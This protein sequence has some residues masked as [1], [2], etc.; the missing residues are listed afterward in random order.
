MKVF[1]F[2]AFDGVPW[3]GEVSMRYAALTEE[4]IRN[5]HEVIYITSSFSHIRK[6]FRKVKDTP[7]GLKVV[8]LKTKSYSKNY[9][10]D[11]FLSYQYLAVSLNNWLNTVSAEPPPA[12]VIG[13][14]PP[15][16]TNYVLAKYCRKNDIPFI[17][18]IQ[19][20]WPEEFLKF[21]P[22]K[23]VQ[24]IILKPYF[25]MA[26]RIVEM[27][28]AIVSILSDFLDYYK[29]QISDKP[30]SVFHLGTDTTKYQ[31]VA[32]IFL[33]DNKMKTVIA[34]GNSSYGNHLIKLARVV[35]HFTDLKLI[36]I[37]LNEK[38]DH[39][40]KRIENEKLHNIEIIPWMAETEKYSGIPAFN[41][42]VILFAPGSK[43]AF[44]NRA[45]TYFA[46]GLPVIN[47]IRGGELEKCIAENNLGISVNFGEENQMKDA[48]EYCLN[49]FSVQ[50]HQRIQD[51]AKANF[52][53]ADIYKQYY[54][55]AIEIANDQ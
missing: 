55:W 14:S 30:N 20:L 37:G 51:Y 47:T 9:S 26:E 44:P 16:E 6:E 29:T 31:N 27:S 32:D 34:M 2:S 8:L 41:A 24:R 25:S 7:S 46:A 36:I 10:I 35:Q 19:D 15:L 17:Y 53:R 52:D 21:L 39:I 54:K 12:L 22:A 23:G 50:E 33:S 1:I 3:A 45:F 48:I 43:Y 13:A 18:D 5:G 38:S 42:G 28:T 11:R 4:F 40:K 49:H